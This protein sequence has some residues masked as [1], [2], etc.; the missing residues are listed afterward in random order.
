[1]LER[2]DRGYILN[3]EEI[4]LV[5][6]VGDEIEIFDGNFFDA[7]RAQ[8]ACVG[9]EEVDP[10]ECRHDALQCRRDRVGVCHVHGH[11]DGGVTSALGINLCGCLLDTFRVDV[12]QRHPGT[13]CGEISRDFQ[14][15]ALCGAGDHCDLACGT[16]FGSGGHSR[17]GAERFDRDASRV[18]RKAVAQHGQHVIAV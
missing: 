15:E 1:M 10:A 11:T 9:N 8:H 6:H 4:S 3:A 17:V 16:S 12:G 5:V 7:A 13:L 14:T 18:G 2:H